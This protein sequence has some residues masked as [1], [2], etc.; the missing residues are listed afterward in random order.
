MSPLTKTAH[1]KINCYAAI[2]AYHHGTTQLMT[3]HN[4]Y[5]LRQH[6]CLNQ[7]VSDHYMSIIPHMG[8]LGDLS[9]AGEYEHV[10]CTFHFKT[11]LC[12]FR[13]KLILTHGT[14]G[15]SICPMDNGVNNSLKMDFL[16]LCFY[17]VTIIYD[18]INKHFFL[19]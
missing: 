6:I 8:D 1:Q 7:G 14:N 13:A 2:T 10:P 18:S 19:I 9:F 16:E 4:K 5:T 15:Q 3:L 12:A 17:G 11:I